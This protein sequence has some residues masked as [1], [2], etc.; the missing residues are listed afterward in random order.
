M[1]TAT[2]GRLISSCCAPRPSRSWS[3]VPPFAVLPEVSVRA[4]PVAARAQVAA[5]H[6]R[7][8]LVTGVVGHCAILGRCMWGGQKQAPLQLVRSVTVARLGPDALAC[9]A[10]AS[11]H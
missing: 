6:D 10:A 9:S 11:A 2:S 1:G 3:Q 8:F 5:V 4:R 7:F